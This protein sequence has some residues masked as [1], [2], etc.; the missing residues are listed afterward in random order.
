MFDDSVHVLARTRRVLD[1]HV[2]PVV[3][4]DR[5]PLTTSAWHVPGE[6]V[7]VADALVASRDRCFRPV[8][9]GTQ[10][11]EPWSTWWFE[12]TGAVPE[13][14]AGEEVE[15]VVDLGFTAEG[16]GF[17][18]EGLLHDAEGTPLKGIHPQNRWHRITR[19]AT[20]G[21]LVHLFL[22]AAGNPAVM[23]HGFR[24][25]L[26]GDKATAGD[27]PRYALGRIDLA[28]LDREVFGLAMDLDVLLDLASELPER[29]ARRLEVC[30]GLD[31]ALTRLD[32]HDVASSAAS[33]R[34]ALVTVLQAPANASAQ[35]LTAVG[36]AHIDTAWLWPVRETVRKCARTFT[37][38]TALA[39]DYPELTFACSSAQQYAWM[40]ERQ[41]SLWQRIHDA[42]DAGT[43]EPVGGMWVEADGMMPS[44]ESLVRQL[45]HGQ[46]FF[47][48]ELGRRCTGVWLPD[49]FGYSAAWP[50][51][52]KLAGAQWFLTQ[53]LSWN[54][55][56]TFPH[57]TFWWEGIDGT[58]ILTHFPPADTY[59]SKLGGAD[60]HRS[61]RRHLDKGRSRR[62][63]IPFGFGDGGGGPEREMLERARRLRSLEGSP[64]VEVGTAQSF[65]DGVR[66]EYAAH[67]PTWTGEL[68]LELHRGTLTSQRAMKAGNR[69]CEA[70]LRQA[71]LVWTMAVLRGVGE[72]PGERL[73]TVWERLLLLQFHDILPGSAIAWVHAEARDDFGRVVDELE[74]LVTEGIESL[75]GG[76]LNAGP[77]ARRE[78][79]GTGAGLRLVAAPALSVGPGRD[80]EPANPVT[81]DRPTVDSLT[82]DN[83]LVRVV[84]GR[85]GSI[86]S[87][88][89]LRHGGADGREV[90]PEG[91]RA[92][93]LRLHPDVPE[94]W[95]A[96]DI[97]KPHSRTWAAPEDVTVAVVEAGP[98]RVVVEARSVIGRSR[99]VQRTSLAAD[100]PRVDVEVRVDWRERERALAA[101]VPV[102]VLAPHSSADI[103][104]G[105]LRRPTHE[106]T[107]WEA[108]RHEMVAHRW[109]HVGE[110][111]W[112]VGLVNESTYGHSV[113]RSVT[114]H[115]E[116]VTTMRLTLLRSPSFPD[117][118]T[119]S[120][121][122][123]GEH[124]LRFGI[125]AGANVE[126]TIEHGYA[127]HLP[128]V[129]EP[130]DGVGSVGED[131]SGSLIEVDGRGVV[132]EAVKLAE[133]GSGD[134]IVRFYESLGGRREVVVRAGFPVVRVAE[135]DLLE[136]EDSAGLQVR[137]SLETSV[138][139]TGTESRL[140]GIRLR[141]RPFQI[142]TLRLTPA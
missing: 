72:W 82:L 116:P 14:F 48:R 113:R 38:V 140:S 90:L 24:P 10:W 98:L 119:D 141:L 11:G 37:N 102:S 39:A 138:P 96:W 84:V 78:V 75:G 35:R 109:L 77:F 2:W 89:D 52:A 103:Q 130:G 57:H 36:H 20:E 43:W 126:Q 106:N 127:V 100:S 13:E 18:A 46:R 9:P 69:R 95:D 101:Y 66:E 26:L 85:D 25:T 23:E 73:R 124:V 105:H 59:E 111:G 94:K 16:P 8:G 80:V 123:V 128:L 129:G 131:D 65:F 28:V 5:M 70:L 79:I 40:K 3:H 60:V 29:D 1:E 62:A 6:P 21:E 139:D 142:V 54:D 74:A 19:N 97:D 110:Q 41:P 115:G 117:P 49:S 32:V 88:H 56:N 118:M 64:A 31:D 87:L 71:E 91:A 51:I 121:E 134:V 108:A 67:A 58:R 44:G 107:S 120:S 136:D 7:P 33:A 17:Q 86:E 114:A 104:F 99:L 30:A 122:V 12:I 76:L 133:D 27:E 135:T 22:E 53:K 81:L 55:T 93:E 4:R 50:Q 42:V 92:A 61:A 63:L 68:Y 83:G 132:V 125:V 47:E 137:R 112:G 45:L 15:V 34:E